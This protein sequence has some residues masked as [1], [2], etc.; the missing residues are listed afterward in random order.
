MSKSQVMSPDNPMLEY[1]RQPHMYS[2]EDVNNILPPRPV[3]SRR[4]RLSPHA[5]H[6][7]N[8]YPVRSSSLSRIMPLPAIDDHGPVIH[9]RRGS[10]ADVHD[11]VRQN[12]NLDHVHE[13]APMRRVPTADYQIEPIRQRSN[14]SQHALDNVRQ[15]SNVEQPQ[16][17]QQQKAQHG[18][19]MDSVTGVSRIRLDSEGPHK[20]QGADEE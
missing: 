11:L 18:S 8:G 14:L 9:S 19:T 6:D 17:Q 3:T 10:E 12:S 1:P 7:D 13:P 4:L 16:Q 15:P 5:L 20:R 2:A